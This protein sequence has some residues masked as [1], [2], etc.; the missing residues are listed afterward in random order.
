M[1]DQSVAEKRLLRLCQEAQRDRAPHGATPVFFMTWAYA[2]R[3]EMTVRIAEAY[4][5]AGND[6]DVLVIPAGLAFARV[7]K[8][9]PDIDFYVFDKRHPTLAGS[10]LAASTIFSSLYGQSPAGLKFTG[11]MPHSIARRLQ[12]AAWA[13]VQEYYSC[14]D[15]AM[16]C[17]SP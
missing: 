8:D 10:Y 16:A 14:Y 7:R 3:P 4:T 13:T 1:H 6:N 9:R 11:G 2:D 17:W 15:G 5:K 12:E